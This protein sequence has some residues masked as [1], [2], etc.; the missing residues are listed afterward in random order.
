[1]SKSRGN[2]VDPDEM[3]QSYGADTLRLFILFASPPE[4]EFAWNEKGIE[5]SFRFLKRVWSFVHENFEVFTLSNPG[6]KLSE[7]AG[8]PGR[9]VKIKQHQ[10]IKKVHPRYREKVS[11]EYCCQRHNGILQPLENPC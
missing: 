10:T 5:G 11:S 9:I 7:G 3:I 1:M 2:V 4:R 6:E 8:L